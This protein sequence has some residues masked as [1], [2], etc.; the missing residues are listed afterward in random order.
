MFTDPYEARLI[1]NYEGDESHSDYIRQELQIQGLTQRTT[2]LNVFPVSP[3]SSGAYPT[4]AAAVADAVTKVP[5]TTPRSAVV[6][7]LE[8]GKVHPVDLDLPA[9]HSFHFI[10]TGY[11]LPP[12]YQNSSLSG[13]LGVIVH[14]SPP[15]P[16]STHNRLTFNG[17][18]LGHGG[19]ESLTI[20]SRYGWHIYLNRCLQLAC[21]FEVYHDPGISGT[22]S[23]I[24]IY[25][26]L[27]NTNDSFYVHYMNPAQAWPNNSTRLI[28]E[29][30]NL[31]AS[32]YLP[33]NYLFDGVVDAEFRNCRFISAI[34]FGGSGV[35]K[36]QPGATGTVQF[37]ECLWEY[38]ALVP[39]YPMFDP[40]FGGI[41]IQWY[42]INMFAEEY[43]FVVGPVDFSNPAS[44]FNGPCLI[45]PS[46]PI[47]PPVG[48]RRRDVGGTET[49]LFWNGIAWV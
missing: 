3:T 21:Y 6:I 35:F 24:L 45:G 36:A 43:Q 22:D 18:G 27:C 25:W 42:G 19:S 2:S 1:G 20:Q 8:A 32:D 26:N 41:N 49:E 9:S 47:S 29:N 34:A 39:P 14:E 17:V 7:A 44:H 11:A 13:R 28:F 15:S 37:N 23:G 12:F 10:T 38:L 48:T 31:F 33:A 5:I 46:V 4:V 16:N 40:N 30:S